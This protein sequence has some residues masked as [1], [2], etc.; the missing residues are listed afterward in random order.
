MTLSL[1]LFR[2]WTDDGKD[3]NW[4]VPVRAIVVGAVVVASVVLLNAIVV[5]VAL[6]DDDLDRQTCWDL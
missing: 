1:H 2:A 5:V 6:A 3:G 4:K